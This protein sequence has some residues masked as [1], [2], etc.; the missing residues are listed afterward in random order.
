[1]PE[2]KPPKTIATI[3]FKGGVGKTTMTWCLGDYISTY[4]NDNT[5]IFDLDA[6]MSLTQAVTL[7]DDG[8]IYEQFGDWSEKSYQK[9]KTIFY[10]IFE[11]I[12]DKKF[13]FDIDYDFI[14][15]IT[16]KYH[17]IPSVEELY[18]LELELGAFDRKLMKSFMRD[19]L[20]KISCSQDV[21][22]YNYILF[23]CPPSFTLL[24]YSILSCC[25]LILIPVNPDFYAVKGV[26]LI[27]NALKL[28]IQPFPAPKIAVFMNKAKPHAGGMTKESKFYW[29][30]VKRICYDAAK[31]TGS[32]IQC[33]DTPI[34]DRADIK[35]SVIGKNGIPQNFVPDFKNL[36]DNVVRFING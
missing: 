32:K 15:K 29:D 23:D 18:W 4:Q 14:Y 36:W 27:L 16:E 1:M 30:T 7:N 28:K 24:S 12:S 34:Y 9:K 2:K 19:L 31:E 10:A 20:G 3:N 6:Q 13:N 33:L 22:G 26:P 25:D 21:L 8:S 17:F 35:R 5:L 11:Y